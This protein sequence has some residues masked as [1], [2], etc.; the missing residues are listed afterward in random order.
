MSALTLTLDTVG[1]GQAPL[2]TER[3]TVEDH[4]I[5]R[6][7]PLRPCRQPL[8]L[9]DRSRKQSLQSHRFRTRFRPRD[10]AFLRTFLRY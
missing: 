8:E 10:T 4:Q 3:P 7:V 5:V 6:F 2:V 1:P 9:V